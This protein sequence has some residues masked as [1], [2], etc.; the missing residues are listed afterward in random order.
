MSNSKGQK[1]LIQKSVIY[2]NI[3][4]VPI[5]MIL[6]LLFHMVSATDFIVM[7]SSFSPRKSLGSAHGV[8]TQPLN[9]TCPSS[10]K[11]E[12]FDLETL[13]L[14]TIMIFNGLACVSE[15][16]ISSNF[17]I[18]YSAYQDLNAIKLYNFSLDTHAIYEIPSFMLP[19]VVDK[20]DI[21][22]G[23][24][25]I[26]N[27][28][29]I[30]QLT[31]NSITPKF[32]FDPNIYF[33]NSY[34]AYIEELQIFIASYTSNVGDTMIT[35]KNWKIEQ[36]YSINFSISYIHYH[37][38]ELKMLVRAN[39]SY[40]LLSFDLNTSTFKVLLVYDESYLSYNGAS[41]VMNDT[42][43]TIFGNV[44]HDKISY[45]MK[46]NLVNLHHNLIEL[47]FSSAIICIRKFI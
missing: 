5:Q 21:V 12:H 18:Y 17:N 35:I 22:Y 23:T 38:K 15:C 30:S 40:Q 46:T 10:Y 34:V 3:L 20:N 45:L 27:N 14:K 1:K 6:I 37:D 16:I 31:N 43:Y 41:I 24:D 2:L 29:V 9:Q 32:T 36:L 42:L 33:P 19:Y 39:G 13:R 28:Y 4:F 25:L 8:R 11:L 44:F 7:T 47:P 26:S